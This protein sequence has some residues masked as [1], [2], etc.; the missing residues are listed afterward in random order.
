M[1]CLVLFKH[2]SKLPMLLAMQ[3]RFEG[4]VT[5]ALQVGIP[6]PIDQGEVGLNTACTWHNACDGPTKQLQVFKLASEWTSTLFE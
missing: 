1:N 3:Y 4:E 6:C 5:Q 2:L